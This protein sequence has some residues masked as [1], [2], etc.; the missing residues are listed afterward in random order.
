[1]RISSTLV[2]D[3][4]SQTIAYAEQVVDRATG[5]NAYKHLGNAPT[6]RD[7]AKAVDTLLDGGVAGNTDTYKCS[8][9]ASEDD[10]VKSMQIN[11]Y[12]VDSNNKPLEGT[13]LICKL[14]NGNSADEIKVNVDGTGNIP[15]YIMGE[16]FSYNCNAGTIL[17]LLYNSSDERF[18][19][20]GDN[21][22]YMA[23]R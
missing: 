14:T 17:P 1:M 23:W 20:V 5:R 6:M 18:E 16:P 12:K 2:N 4:A 13:M 22:Y 11:N 21:N 10:Q 3:D 15:V 7:I 9:N 8:T 19:V